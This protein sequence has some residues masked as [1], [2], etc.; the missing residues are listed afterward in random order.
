MGFR[1][2]SSVLLDYVLVSSGEEKPLDL[3][4]PLPVK[5]ASVKTLDGEPVS[6]TGG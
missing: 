4:L 2:F 1:L 5:L 3:K 6:I